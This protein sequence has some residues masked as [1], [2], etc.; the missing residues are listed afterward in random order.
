MQN[1]FLCRQVSGARKDIEFFWNRDLVEIEHRMSRDP[2]VPPR[3][4]PIV[5]TFHTSEEARV[6]LIRNTVSQRNLISS[7]RLRMRN[8]IETLRLRKLLLMQDLRR[9]NTLGDMTAA[10]RFI[11]ATL[12]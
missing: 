12:D 10:D 9:V 6:Y 11:N 2:L 3:P 1:A 4:P 7:P 8:D 5:Y